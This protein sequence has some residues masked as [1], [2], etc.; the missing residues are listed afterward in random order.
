M[1]FQY[2]RVEGDEHVGEVAVVPAL[3]LSARP[4]LSEVVAAQDDFVR[5]GDERL[6]GAGREHVVRA[7]H[8]V[9]GFLHRLA[10]ERYVH[11]HLVAVEVR[12]EGGADERVQLDGAALHERGHERLYAEPVQRG[13]AVQQDG[14]GLDD[15]LQDVPDL[16]TGALHHSLG[17]LDVVRHALHDE[18]VHDERLE[19]LQ[20]H[21]LR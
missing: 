3:S 13:R 16:G 17:A 1:Q 5:R 4:R 11:G 15:L 6:A 9:A 2:P 7:E 12:V 19:E 8:H 18:P 14:A 21:L 10:G 20:R